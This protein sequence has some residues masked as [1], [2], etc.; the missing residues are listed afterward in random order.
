MEIFGSRGSLKIDFNQE[1]KIQFF[2][3]SKNHWIIGDSLPDGIRP[4]NFNPSSWPIGKRSLG[5]FMDSHIASISSFLNC[6]EKNIPSQ[7]NF[8]AAL[9][10]QELLHA[11]YQSAA[12]DGRKIVINE[13]P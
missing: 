3:A 6:L 8:Q 1:T 4:T 13:R 10:S 2:D 5:R 9:Q 12:E 11:A 7:I